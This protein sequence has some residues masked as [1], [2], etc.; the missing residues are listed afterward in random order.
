[1]VTPYKKLKD[2]FT[3]LAKFP[4]DRLARYT[5]ENDFLCIDENFFNVE[6]IKSA[7]L[8]LKRLE[9]KDSLKYMN[10]SKF[11]THSY[12][13][14][15]PCPFNPGHLPPE[16]FER[17][18]PQETEVEVTFDNISLE[19]SF[20]GEKKKGWIEPL[21]SEFLPKVRNSFAKA[22][23][24]YFYGDEKDV[25]IRDRLNFDA[26]NEAPYQMFLDLFGGALRAFSC[27]VGFSRPNLEFSSSRYLDDGMESFRRGVGVWKGPLG[28]F[29]QSAQTIENAVRE[30]NRNRGYKTKKI[31]ANQTRIQLDHPDLGVLLI[32]DQKHQ[33]SHILVKG[34]KFEWV[35][36]KLP[37][38]FIF[39][40]N[41]LELMERDKLLQRN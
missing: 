39:T 40:N 41:A 6:H 12:S 26:E 27:F 33:Y 25:I 38:T 30:M 17:I 13:D 19:V 32:T 14:K 4:L 29:V 1:M 15:A 18:I 10:S 34:G 5:Y 7:L 21:H 28:D 16:Y 35:N 20:W 36:S 11:R 37:S 3:G 31:Y 8:S 24:R 2:S 22:N 23:P 9:G